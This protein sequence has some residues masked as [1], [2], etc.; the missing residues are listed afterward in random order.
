MTVDERKIKFSIITYVC[1][2]KLPTYVRFYKVIENLRSAK[3]SA[4]FSMI[5]QIIIVI[6][7]RN[8]NHYITH[9]Y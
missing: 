9:K 6:M 1:F 7:L 2:I 8:E 4:W 5:R 3:G